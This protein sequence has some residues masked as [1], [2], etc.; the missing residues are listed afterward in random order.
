MQIRTPFNTLNQHGFYALLLCCA[1][2]THTKSR[3]N[4]THLDRLDTDR[5]DVFPFFIREKNLNLCARDLCENPWLN[6]GRFQ[7]WALVG[8]I[9]KCREPQNGPGVVTTFSTTTTMV[10]S[11]S[12]VLDSYRFHNDGFF[13]VEGVESAPIFARSI[14]L[15]G[16][17]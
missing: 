5:A 12:V 14:P 2:K 1:Y 7:Y 17:I 6:C 9:E 16:L 4:P 13:S 15:T 8:D 10:S 11:S 3:T